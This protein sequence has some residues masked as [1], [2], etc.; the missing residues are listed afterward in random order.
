MCVLKVDRVVA[1]S[2]RLS[3]SQSVP[4]VHTYHR[5]L[6]TSLQGY[7]VLRGKNGFW[8]ILQRAD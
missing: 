8:D 1:V 2:T 3:F 4:P 5:G 7:H 6:M